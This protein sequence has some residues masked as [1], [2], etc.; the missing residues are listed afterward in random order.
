MKANKLILGFQAVTFFFLLFTPIYLYFLFGYIRICF[1]YAPSLLWQ[2]LTA[3]IAGGVLFNL[4]VS[5]LLW[6]KCLF[7]EKKIC[8]WQYLLIILW[9]SQMV[10]CIPLI[11]PGN[12]PEIT[13]AIIRFVK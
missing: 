4:L 7:K 10:L 12:V 5:P 3:V 2:I 1:I 11:Q 8:T 9:L 13:D 6:W